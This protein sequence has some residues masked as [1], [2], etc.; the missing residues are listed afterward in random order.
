MSQPITTFADIE[1]A[2]R[3]VLARQFAE[4]QA[5]MALARAGRSPA[6][7]AAQADRIIADLAAMV[8]QQCQQQQAN[9]G[10][11]GVRKVFKTSAGS[12]I[13]D[14]RAEAVAKAESMTAERP[15]MVQGPNDTPS[16]RELGIR[17]QIR[18]MNRAGL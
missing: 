1:A 7:L 13:A 12:I 11:Y 2:Q 18:R 3:A 16:L 17:A 6:Q 10:L 9:A 4:L 8:P 14:T 15:V 5:R